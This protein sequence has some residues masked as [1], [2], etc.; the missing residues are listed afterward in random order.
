[1]PKPTFPGAASFIP[2]SASMPVLKDAV[3]RC[4]G[5]DLYRYA[6]QGVFGEGVVPARIV[7]IGEQPG[8]DEDLQGRPFIGPSGKLLN[9]ALVD[10]GIERSEVYVTNAVKHFKFEERGKRRIHKKPGS[11]EV[12]ACRPW[13]DIELAIVKPRLVVCLGATAAQ[14][15]LGNSFRLTQQRGVAIPGSDRST[16]VATI[17]PSAILR[18]AD[19]SE[20]RQEYARFVED[21]KVGRQ[22]AA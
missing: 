2:D 6:T 19:Q 9:R 7:L 18:L 14:A 1:V 5:C 3:N 20:R 4:E 21:L 8:N 15:M 22:L 12:K 17:H 16:I 10:A 11:A 13:L